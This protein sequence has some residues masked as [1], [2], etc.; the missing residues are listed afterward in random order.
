MN[1]A[2][3]LTD[4]VDIPITG[5]VGLAQPTQVR[6]KETVML[7]KEETTKILRDNYTYLAVEYGVNRIGLFGSYAKDIPTE[8]SDVDIIVEFNRPLGFRFFALVE[9]LESILGKNVDVLTPA[10]IQ[11]IRLDGIA[12]SIEE[13]IVYV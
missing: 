6:R 7:T 10:G 8:E 9:Y 3:L 11:G 1:H 12:K 13:S 2:R 5:P 4:S